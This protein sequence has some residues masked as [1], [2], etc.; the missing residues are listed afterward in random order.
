MN[1]IFVREP[2]SRH[3]SKDRFE[4]HTQIFRIQAD[5]DRPRLEDEVHCVDIAVARDL[6]QEAVWRVVGEVVSWNL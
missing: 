4:E 6:F 1:N 3:V 5:E 2:T